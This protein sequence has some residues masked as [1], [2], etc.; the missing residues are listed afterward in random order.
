MIEKNPPLPTQPAREFAHEL[1]FK[2]AREKL[3]AI[4][5]IEG[6]CRKSGARYLPAEKSVIIDYLNRFYRISLPGGEVSSIINNEPVPLRD[7]ILIL[8]YFN[9]ASGTPLSG[10]NI[11]YKELAEGINYYPTFFKRAIEPIINSFKDDPRLLLEASAT[12]GGHKTDYGDMAVAIDA[13]PL[14]PVTVVIWRGDKEFPPNGNIM[15]DST[16]PEYLPTEDITILCEIL[17][18]KLVRLIKT[19]GDA[20]GKR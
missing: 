12:L 19:G 5:D 1:A 2:L 14:V 18:W 15:F 9:R 13:F 6:Q 8:H 7:K 3:A 16:I 11:T 10:R 20:P 4:A 17:A